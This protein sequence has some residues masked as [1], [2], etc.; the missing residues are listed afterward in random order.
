MLSRDRGS[1]RS[2]GDP[3]R[4]RCRSLVSEGEKDVVAWCLRVRRSAQVQDSVRGWKALRGVGVLEEVEEGQGGWSMRAIVSR[5]GSGASEL[6]MAF[7][8]VWA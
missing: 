2:R 1:E 6:L 4:E 7:K 8:R 5:P 3:G